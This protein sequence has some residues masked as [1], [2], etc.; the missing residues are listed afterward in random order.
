MYREKDKSLK[1]NLPNNEARNLY[2]FVENMGRLNFGNDYLDAKVIWYFKLP[3]KLIY[4]K[5]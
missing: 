4:F 2:I 1:I 3:N 5:Q